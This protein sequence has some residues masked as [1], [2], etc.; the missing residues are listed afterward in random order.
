MNASISREEGRQNEEAEGVTSSINVQGEE[1]ALIQVLESKLSM[2][3]KAL[4][5]SAGRSG[6]CIFRVHPGFTRVKVQSYQPRIVSIGPYHHGQEQLKMMEEH[7]WRF[8]ARVVKRTR[9]KKEGVGLKH[10]LEAVRELEAVARA[11]YSEAIDL[12]SDE[13][14]EMLVLD[15]CFV[16]EMFRAFS[17][18]VPFEEDDPFLSM[19]WLR[20]SLRHD[21]L[22]LENQIPFSVLEKLFKLTE[23]GEKSTLK[24]TS[25][26]SCLSLL[27]LH[28]FDTTGA[29]ARKTEG[30]IRASSG[31]EFE[32]LHLLDLVR[33]SYFPKGSR[34]QREPGSRCKGNCFGSKGGKYEYR[35]FHRISKLRKAGIKFRSNK[36]E[37][38]S[39]LAVGF[40]RGTIRMP[41]LTLD[42]TM[43]A[44][45]LNCV[46]F[47][48]CH[49][50]SDRRVSQY[51]VFL[52]CIIDTSEDVDILCE[53]KVLH[54]R[55]A[56]QGEAVAFVGMLA[57][58]A[59]ST[60][61]GE[62]Y[63]KEVFAGL[64]KY[65]DNK[66]HT[67]VAEVKGK[68]FS[69]MPLFDAS[70]HQIRKFGSNLFK[71]EK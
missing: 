35:N 17:G 56:T 45:L 26:T 64:N 4:S 23:M 41:P 1:D 59:A 7:K 42:D 6:C 13:F 48:Q 38:G 8:L 44:F 21:F 16:V 39:F 33:K 55:L 40:K 69:F 14:V 46:A 47:E 20:F 31:H 32:G 36:R 10:Y 61:L 53:A 58:A 52:G 2:S 51:A 37:A 60:K 30:M 19:Q 49:K 63:L 5:K 50:G 3:P 67:H 25:H 70:I 29:F 66:L 15:G 34:E 54:N 65:Y 57:E 24:G 62:S 43:C 12:T 71:K 22:C 18:A 68:Y 27:A 11:S 9:E 28:F